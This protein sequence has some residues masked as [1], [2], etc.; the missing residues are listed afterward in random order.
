MQ[1]LLRY[2]AW[3]F[4]SLASS[5]AAPVHAGGG[6]PPYAPVFE[7]AFK[8]GWR[9]H[10][11]DEHIAFRIFDAGW[12]RLTSG[13]IKACDPF[14]GMEH[15][16]FA[17][18]VPRGDFPVRLALV[19]GG[20]DDS[21]VALARVGFS[22]S[23]AVRWEMAVTEGQD[24][25]TLKEGEHFGYPVDA[26]TGSFVDAETAAVASRS[27]AA[28]EDLAQRWIDLGEKGVSGKGAPNFYASVDIG[29][30]NIIMFQ[31]GWGDG[32]YASWFGYDQ[33]GRI[34]ALVTDFSVVD[35]SKAKW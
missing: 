9:A 20:V 23:P 30:G 17:A 4:A 5:S 7:L 3:L 6:P 32:L 14:V 33:Q 26:G 12:L 31:S 24:I 13:R 25:G 10:I 2:I 18:A 21:R 19:D 35:W 27:M 15:R 11:G 16:P 28:D 8:S 1:R 34:A 29:P 22:P